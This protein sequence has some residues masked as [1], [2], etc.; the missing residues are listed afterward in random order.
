MSN[1]LIFGSGSW[2]SALAIHLARAGHKVNLYTRNDA[3]YYSMIS[4]RCNE[5]YLPGIVFPANLKVTNNWKIVIQTC[6]YI[7]IST[8]SSAF[9]EILQNV[10]PYIK[11]RKLPKTIQ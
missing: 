5:K 8:P 2:G 9:E 4:K 11:K 10:S 3:N 7:L 6:Q 1:F